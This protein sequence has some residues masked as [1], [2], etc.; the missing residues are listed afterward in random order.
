MQQLRSVAKLV[1]ALVERD[2]ANVAAPLVASGV[3]S[4]YPFLHSDALR[5]SLNKFQRYNP[6]RKSHRHNIDVPYLWQF[7]LVDG[8]G[9]H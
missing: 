3:T 6:R 8:R 9:R 2:V 4:L 5:L 1:R 7:S